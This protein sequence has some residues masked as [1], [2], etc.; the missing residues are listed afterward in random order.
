MVLAARVVPK[1]TKRFAIFMIEKS[2]YN[3]P[4]KITLINGHRTDVALVCAL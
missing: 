1:T 3:H 4:F 2:I